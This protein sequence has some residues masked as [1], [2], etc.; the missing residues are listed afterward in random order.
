LDPLGLQRRERPYVLDLDHFGLSDADL[1]TEFF[2]NSR[3]DAIP[4]RAKLEDILE[5]LK[6]I[7]CGSIGAEFA[8]VSDSD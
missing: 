7:Y 3:N 5:T 8:H 4:A 6:F 1:E 2:T